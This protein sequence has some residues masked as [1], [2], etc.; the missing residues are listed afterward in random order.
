MGQQYAGINNKYERKVIC[1]IFLRNSCHKQKVVLWSSV[2][3]IQTSFISFI[4]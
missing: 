3:K 2:W 4:A 1:M